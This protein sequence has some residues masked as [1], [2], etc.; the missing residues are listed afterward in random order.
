[1]QNN[2]GDKNPNKKKKY[3]LKETDTFGKAEQ[4]AAQNLMQQMSETLKKMEENK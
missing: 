1:M 2:E 3:R 4:T